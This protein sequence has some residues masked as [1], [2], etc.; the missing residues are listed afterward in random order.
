MKKF[1][2]ITSAGLVILFGMYLGYKVGR[3]AIKTIRNINELITIKDCYEWQKLEENHSGF[4]L[5]KREVN[6]CA[7]LNIKIK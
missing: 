2:K 1:I 3:Y 5:D 7:E 6:M 4:E